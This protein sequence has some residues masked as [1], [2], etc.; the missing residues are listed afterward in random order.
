[1]VKASWFAEAWPLAPRGDDGVVRG[2]LGIGR[3]V[4]DGARQPIAG[5]ET[6]VGE[7]P[8]RLDA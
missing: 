1:V 2:I 6:A 3:V 4:K 8:E 5:F 7:R